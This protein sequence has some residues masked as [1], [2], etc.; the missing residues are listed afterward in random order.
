[1]FFDFCSIPLGAVLALFLFFDERPFGPRVV[2]HFFRFADRQGCFCVFRFAPFSPTA[3]PTSATT[4][5]QYGPAAPHGTRRMR[6][7]PL[8]D[9]FSPAL[10]PARVGARR[11]ITIYATMPC[12]P[13]LDIGARAMAAE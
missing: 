12:D 8:I 6:R 11:S 2:F 3:N 7:S 4:F 13:I 5:G 1:L 9:S 10:Y